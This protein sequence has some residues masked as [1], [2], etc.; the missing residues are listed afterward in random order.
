MP[1]RTLR[2]IDLGVTGGF[3]GGVIV[4]QAL[5]S[6][7]PRQ[8]VNASSRFWWLLEVKLSPPAQP[9]FARSFCS[10]LCDTTTLQRGPVDGTS[11]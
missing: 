8:V 10:Q 9:T 5:N 11:L 2:R 3:I 7:S 6:L 1:S 4:C